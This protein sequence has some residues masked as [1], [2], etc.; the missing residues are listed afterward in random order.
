MKQSITG[1]GSLSR[2][3][4]AILL[5][6]VMLVTG[7]ALAAD[8]SIYIDQTG[9]NAS[10]TINQDGGGNAVRGLP[11]VGTSNTTPATI[12]GDGN[13]VSVS[14]VGS[15]N[16][17]KLGIKTDTTVG[18]STVNY[19]VT[20]QNAS[21]IIQVGNT[22]TNSSANTINVTQDGN[23]SVASVK[24]I[25]AGNTGTINTSGGANNTAVLGMSGDN[26]TG[27]TTVTGGGGNTVSLDL[28]SS[29]GSATVTA[30]GASN[31]VNVLQTGGVNGH[32]TTVDLTGS[33]NTVGIMQ[34]GTAGDNTINLKS[35]GSTNS[36]SINQNNR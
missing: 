28:Q 31:T 26:I 4:T 5:S 29:G 10:V 7:V 22:Q 24:S 14:Q 25:G 3:L 30:A 13:Q 9:D 6:A 1:A 20:G 21:A 27:T 15:G 23:N 2:K 18:Q 35:V 16:T 36:F 19:S 11:G 32:S 33:G 17:L 12:Y 8:N 34:Q